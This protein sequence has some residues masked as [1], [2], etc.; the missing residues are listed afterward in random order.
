MDERKLAIDLLASIAAPDGTVSVSLWHDQPRPYFKVY[1]ATNADA[2]R[3]A[4]PPN[5][6]GYPVVVESMP[7][8][9]MF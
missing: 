5:F 2:Q 9:S 1:V 6:Y 8:F 3:Q 7:E 4:I